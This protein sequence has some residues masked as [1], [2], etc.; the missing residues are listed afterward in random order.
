[1]SKVDKPESVYRSIASTAS[2]LSILPQP[3]LVC[4]IPLRTLHISNESFPLL[5]LTRS[6]S[7]VV[8]VLELES[9]HRINLALWQILRERESIL[10]VVDE[11]MQVKVENRLWL[12][13]AAIF[14]EWGR[15]G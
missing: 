6:F 13:I 15:R 3:P 11:L 8:L 10:V 1:M 7:I 9:L 4:H 12:D 14:E 2:S 5:S